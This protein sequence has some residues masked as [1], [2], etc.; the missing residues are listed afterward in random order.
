A[1]LPEVEM[2]W[3]MF[4]ENFTLSGLLEHETHIGD[5]LRVGTAL[6]AI[7][8]PRTPCYKLG[9]KFGRAD[10]VKRFLAS[11]RTGSYLSVLEE[12]QVGAGDAVEFLSS[13]ESEITVADITSLFMPTES[14]MRT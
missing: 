3:G 11:R 7:T 6:F 1:Q 9:I 4:G 14:R 2:D 5:R 10:M 8:Q 12:G 13:G